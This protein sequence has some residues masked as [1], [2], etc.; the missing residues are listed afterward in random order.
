MANE[1]SK[2][3]EMRVKTSHSIVPEERAESLL[4]EQAGGWIP[5]VQGLKCETF[6][7][8]IQIIAS[9]MNMPSQKKHA[10]FVVNLR[11]GGSDT[12]LTANLGRRASMIGSRIMRKCEHSFDR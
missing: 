5:D 2:R 6:W 9:M 11:D 10:L 8:S 4:G 12:E 1:I 7:G 3:H